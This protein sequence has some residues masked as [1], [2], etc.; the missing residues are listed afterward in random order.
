MEHTR[1]HGKILHGL[2]YVTDEADVA[3]CLLQDIKKHSQYCAINGSN[4]ELKWHSFNMDVVC[5]HGEKVKKRKRDSFSPNAL[6]L[7]SWVNAIRNT[8]TVFGKE[9]MPYQPFQNLMVMDFLF[10]LIQRTCPTEMDEII[11]HCKRSLSLHD[12]TTEE[13]RAM[14]E[15]F[16]IK[17]SVYIIPRRHG[18]TSM[19]TALMG[20]TV[21]FIDKIVIGYGCH[22]KKALK[23]AFKTTLDVM[24]NIQRCAHLDKT[25][26]QTLA[27]ESI[28]VRN[29][30]TQ[31]SS[32][33]L[34]ISLQNDKVH[35]NTKDVSWI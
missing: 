14:K 30:D 22:R 28:R 10:Y 7:L 6:A 5:G 20:A 9:K 31:Q 16:S 33:I 2:G 25:R 29:Q 34:F 13:I 4:N 21:L 35:V 27:G 15:K 24:S 32:S 23:E 1:R 19:F 3:C 17:H 18:K 12:V 8:L 11:H 26:I